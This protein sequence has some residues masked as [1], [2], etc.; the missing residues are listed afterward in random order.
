MKLAINKNLIESLKQAS[1]QTN[2]TLSELEQLSDNLDNKNCKIIVMNSSCFVVFQ[3]LINVE[4]VVEDYEE[5]SQL[6]FLD[7]SSLTLI[8]AS[9]KNVNYLQFVLGELLQGKTNVERL[10]RLLSTLVPLAVLNMLGFFYASEHGIRD[11]FTGLLTAASIFVAIFSLFVTSNDY[12]TRKKIE[13]FESGQL[14]YYFNIDKHITRTGIYAILLSL[15]G[16]VVSSAYDA[17]RQLYTLEIQH[18]IVIALLNLIFLAVYF[19]LRSMV[20]FYIIRPGK[21][22][23]SDLK[24]DSFKRYRS[25]K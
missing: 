16:L 18:L 9:G 10:K 12:I 5:V 6:Q 24:S 23:M 1:G 25:D 4:F 2:L 14:D 20:E 19:I 11:I 8:E 3:D 13:L 15:F 7:Q 22:I 17:N 21:F